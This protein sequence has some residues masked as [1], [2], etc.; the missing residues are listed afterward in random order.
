MTNQSYYVGIDVGGTNVRIGLVDEQ[1][2]IL[3]DEKYKSTDIVHKFNEV[4]EKFV[5]KYQSDYPIKAIS[6]GYPGLADQDSLNV[7]FVPNQK[8][9]E[10]TYLNDLQ[11]K[12]NIPIV[13]GNDTNYL[14]LYDAVY[15]GIPE[16]QSILGFYLGTGFGNAIRIKN[17]LYQGDTGA[18]GEIGHVPVYLNGVIPKTGKQPDLESLVSGFNLIEIHQKHFK[19]TPFEEMLIKHF[20]SDIVQTYLHM[21]AYYIVTEMIMLD[22]TTIILGGG[23]IMSDQFPREYLEALIKKNLLTDLQRKRFKAYYAEPSANSGVVGAA[24]YAKS[25]N[26]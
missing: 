16:N 24:I 10:G 14:M 12:L 15:F 9:F 13:V 3:F 23:V 2:Q 1:N 25:F 6:I 18:A 7:Y 17:Q 26:K 8:A 21:L 20:D 5:K 19:E 11:Q 4:I 22:V